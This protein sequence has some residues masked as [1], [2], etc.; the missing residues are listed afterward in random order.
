MTPRKVRDFALAAAVS[1]ALAGGC[2]HALVLSG[3]LPHPVE[4]AAWVAAFP[5]LVLGLFLA[6]MAPRGDPDI[7]FVGY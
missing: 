1:A 3:V 6:W 4:V 2:A 5:V 7:P